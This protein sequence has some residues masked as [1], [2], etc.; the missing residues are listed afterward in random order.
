MTNKVITSDSD[1]IT[2]KTSKNIVWNNITF[3]VIDN[4]LYDDDRSKM[5]SR[6]HIIILKIYFKY[7]YNW[8]ITPNTL[9]ILKKKNCYNRIYTQSW[10]I[11]E[12]KNFLF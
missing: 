11:E 1:H 4:L 8:K 12:K 9:F 6:S 5:Y 2:I 3:Y 7:M 10:L